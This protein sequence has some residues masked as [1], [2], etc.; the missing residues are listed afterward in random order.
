MFGK[1]SITN[2]EYMRL[3]AAETEIKKTHTYRDRVGLP[4]W[5]KDY[6]AYA[7][8]LPKKVFT[9]DEFNSKIRKTLGALVSAL[10]LSGYDDIVTYVTVPDYRIGAYGTYLPIGDK[11]VKRTDLGADRLLSDIEAAADFEK[12]SKAT[13]RL[14][15]AVQK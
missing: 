7:A 14:R 9:E 5:E 10:G 3:K 13:K 6:D 1:I 4:R 15:K 8:L 11:K 2:D 12:G